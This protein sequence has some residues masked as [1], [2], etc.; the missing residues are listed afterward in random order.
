MSKRFCRPSVAVSQDA[1]PPG[2]LASRYA[3]LILIQRREELKLRANLRVHIEFKMI[4]PEPPNKEPIKRVESPVRKQ[5]R[6][7]ACETR[8]TEQLR[9][10]PH[11][12]VPVRNTYSSVSCTTRIA[13]VFAVNS[14]AWV[15]GFGFPH[16]YILL[17]VRLASLFYSARIGPDHMQIL[18]GDALG[19]RC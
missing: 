16:I 19:I 5:Y 1:R 17:Y 13:A 12:N 11:Y 6:C 18:S 15:S 14:T 8:P 9:I 3:R 7:S 4:R 2:G 10:I